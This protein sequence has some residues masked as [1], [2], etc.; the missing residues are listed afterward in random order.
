MQIDKN[1]KR[2]RVLQQI[3]NGQPSHIYIYTGRNIINMRTMF[4]MYRMSQKLGK[5]QS[6][7]H[8]VESSFGQKVGQHFP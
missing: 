2:P 7:V 4:Y 5:N 1:L 6:K 3:L 8:F